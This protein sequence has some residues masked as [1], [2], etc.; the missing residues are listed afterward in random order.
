MKHCELGA[1]N[2]KKR[3][4]VAVARK[5]AVLLHHL[6]QT[7]EVNEP[8][9]KNE[10]A[11]RDYSDSF[12]TLIAVTKVELQGDGA[13]ASSGSPLSCPPARGRSAARA[14]AGA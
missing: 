8:I 5:L 9:R 11:V 4:V 2:A 3:A 13:P 14:D 10:V 12:E 1:G 6:R 7:G